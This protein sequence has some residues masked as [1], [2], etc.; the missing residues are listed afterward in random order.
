M[1]ASNHQI[2]GEKNEPAIDHR[3]HLPLGTL[4]SRAFGALAFWSM[5][6]DLPSACRPRSSRAFDFVVKNCRASAFSVPMQ[7]PCYDSEDAR[8]ARAQVAP[9]PP[10]HR[11]IGDC[12]R[13]REKRMQE[14]GGNWDPKAVGA[15]S[16][17][18]H[19]TLRLQSHAML[20][21]HYCSD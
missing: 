16:L 6:G 17:F 15:H 9:E 3:C 7:M 1:D 18:L 4:A 8:V 20:A 2:D 19:L 13:A 10:L 5:R 14:N 21:F 12:M 11:S